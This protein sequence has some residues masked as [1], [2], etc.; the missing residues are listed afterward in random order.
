[1]HFGLFGGVFD[2]GSVLLGIERERIRTDLGVRFVAWLEWVADD[3]RNLVAH[4]VGR[5]AGNEDVDR[6]TRAIGR[7]GVG[8]ARLGKHETYFLPARRSR[9][10]AP[11]AVLAKQFRLRAA[12]NGGRWRGRFCGC[13]RRRL[14]CGRVGVCVLVWAWAWPEP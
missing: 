5:S 6:I 10:S 11:H 1:D 4:L 14:W 2:P 7:V 12:R 9:V 13:W 3:Q 8:R